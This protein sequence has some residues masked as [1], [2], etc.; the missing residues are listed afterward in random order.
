VLKRLLIP[1]ERFF[2]FSEPHVMSGKGGKSIRIVSAFSLDF[3]YERV[4]TFCIARFLVRVE[5]EI[6]DCD[7]LSRSLGWTPT[8]RKYFN[9]LFRLISSVVS[10]CDRPQRLA[11][12]ILVFNQ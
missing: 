8:T 9:D 1:S 10:K 11:A 3:I 7:L 6:Q 2:L 5:K 12:L 4:N